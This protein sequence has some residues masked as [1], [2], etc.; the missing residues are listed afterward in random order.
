MR[1]DPGARPVPAL[2]HLHH[3]PGWP[4]RPPRPRPRQHC[5]EDH[6]A[7]GEDLSVLLHPLPRGH[8]LPLPLLH[9]MSLSLSSKVRASRCDLLVLILK[10]ISGVLALLPV[11]LMIPTM[12]STAMTASPRCSLH[13]RVTSSPSPLLC[14]SRSRSRRATRTPPGSPSPTTRRRS[15]STLL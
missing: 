1:R 2:L 9:L 10:P 11:W 8:R 4:G 6:Q 12:T 5:Q 3:A 13:S 14:T 7:R 15:R